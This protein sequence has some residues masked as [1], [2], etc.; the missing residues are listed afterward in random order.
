[1]NNI[2]RALT[3]SHWLPSYTP[4]YYSSDLWKNDRKRIEKVSSV[5]LS[6]SSLSL[7][8]RDRFQEFLYHSVEMFCLISVE[9]HVDIALGNI[10]PFHKEDIM[11]FFI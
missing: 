6:M 9:N 11:F 4:L 5:L 3:W 8:R 1:M 7:D 2:S 10:D